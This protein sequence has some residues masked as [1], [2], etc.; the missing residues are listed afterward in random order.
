MLVRRAR[1]WRVGTL[2]AAVLVALA[3]AS[4]AAAVTSSLERAADSVVAITSYADRIGTGVVIAED[5]VLTVAH[6]VDAAAGTPARVVVGSAIVPYEVIAIDR[7]RDLALLAVDLPD[8][9]PVIVWGDETTLV[10]GQDVIAFG[11]PIGLRSVSLTKGVVSSPEQVFAGAVFIQTDAAINPGNSG[12]PLV[13]EWGRLVGINVAKIAEIEVDAVGFAV[14]GA[15][16]RAFLARVAPEIELLVDPSAGEAPAEAVPVEA[17]RA[18]DLRDA[19]PLTAVLVIVML[20]GAVGWR[21]L[22]SWRG[23][24]GAVGARR[25]SVAGAPGGGTA[26]RERAVFRVVSSGRDEELDLRLPSVAGTAP[27]ADI[28][29]RGEHVK[30]YHIRF[31]A[32][33]DGVFAVDLTDSKGMYCGDACVQSTHLVPGGSVRVGG[34]TIVLVRRYQG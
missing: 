5:R 27:N 31:S 29:L 6:V 25:A 7:R 16:V 3:V 22:R 34:S 11:F 8:D 28:P 21:A 24:A 17:G 2:L 4:P 1:A 12:G 33:P 26:R 30:P 9:T 32:V 15:D 10:R 19:F 18:V 13:D 20:V 14:P 23:A